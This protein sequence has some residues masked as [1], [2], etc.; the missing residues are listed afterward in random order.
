MAENT[1]LA[2]FCSAL[3]VKETP[4]MV[5]FAGHRT[6]PTAK[7]LAR[8]NR[9]Q[10]VGEVLSAVFKTPLTVVANASPLA[11]RLHVVFFRFVLAV[12]EVR[13]KPCWVAKDCPADKEFS[14]LVVVYIA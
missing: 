1:T 7:E 4:L 2:S 12:C 10:T 9:V 14:S 6:P 5:L 13:M 8:C 11:I 3:A